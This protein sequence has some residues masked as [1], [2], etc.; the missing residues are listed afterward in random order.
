MMQRLLQWLAHNERHL[1]ALFFVG[2]FLTDLLTFTLLDISVV[3]MVFAGYLTLGAVFS[4]LGHAA[5][6]WKQKYTNTFFRALPV[7]L[8]LIVQYAIGGLLSGCLIFFTKSST[9]VASWPFLLLLALVFIGNEYFRKY[10]EHLAFQTILL[11]FGLYAFSIFALPLAVH[12]MGP[13]VFLGSTALSLVVFAAFLWLL[14]KSGRERLASTFKLIMGGALVSVVL[15]VGAYFTG[16][17]PPIPLTLSSVGIYQNLTPVTGGYL[18][19]GEAAHSWWQFWPRTIHHVPGTPLYAYSAVFAPV[20]FS[21]SIVHEWQWYDPVQKKWTEQSRV[22]FMISGGRAGGYRGYSIKDNPQPGKW[23]LSIETLS[24][25][26]IGREEFV[27][28]NAASL[29]PLEEEIK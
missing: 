20:S 6:S 2:G 3:T 17:I 1:G 23:R 29:P 21:T 10:R 8:S 13:L 11:F 26:V 18:V 4:L 19:Q 27:V 28:K 15:M 7:I 24:G 9:V 5:E 16:L 22:A 25:L 12:T 14:W